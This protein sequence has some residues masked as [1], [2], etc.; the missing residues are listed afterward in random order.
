VNPSKDVLTGR[1]ATW[2]L[3]WGRRSRL[4]RDQAGVIAAAASDVWVLTEAGCDALP[5][6]WAS[7]ASAEI[8]LAAGASGLV[9]DSGYFAVV[10]APE[11]EEVAVPELPTAA[12]ARVQL[13][14]QTWLVLGV[15]MPW[16]RNRP[17]LPEG[18]APGADDG[19]AQWRT[20]LDR[21]D[22]ALERLAA[23]VDPDRVL[24]AGDLNQTLS[25]R[26]VGFTG[27]RGQLEEVLARHR[28]VAYTTK[29][30]SRLPGCPTVD[31]ICGPALP[32]QL[33]PWPDLAEPLSDHRGY[34]VQL[35]AAASSSPAFLAV[36]PPVLS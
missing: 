22:T 12:C 24:L 23:T 5:D 10:S 30:P 3:D 9:G 2:N 1:V 17:T 33:E 21:L 13:A 31:H 4:R 26:H 8:P 7:V 27:G 16:R 36:P 14:G 29:A 15:C 25:G 35:T 6:G 20:V 32:H 28:L 11:L 19:P 34:I 18:A